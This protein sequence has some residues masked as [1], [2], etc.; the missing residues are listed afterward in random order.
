[1]ITICSVFASDYEP[2]QREPRQQLKNIC[3]QFWMYRNVKV[4]LRIGYKILRSK[5]LNKP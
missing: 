1:M 4:G 2:A 3:A 5:S